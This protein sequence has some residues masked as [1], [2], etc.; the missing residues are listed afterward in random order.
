MPAGRGMGMVP[1]GVCSA[2]A[3]SISI[4]SNCHS[5]WNDSGHPSFCKTSNAVCATWYARS[6]SRLPS[7][8][9][10]TGGAFSPSSWVRWPSSPR[11][12]QSFGCHRGS[13]WLNVIIDSNHRP[14]S[15]E[16]SISLFLLMYVEPKIRKCRF[17]SSH[18]YMLDV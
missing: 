6:T 11:V 18:E 10:P 5:L 4:G 12:R 13:D 3:L 15:S 9:I 1:P 7:A 14:S 16:Q 8:W 2:F 17:V